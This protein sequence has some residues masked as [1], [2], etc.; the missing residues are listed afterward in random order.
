MVLAGNSVHDLFLCIGLDRKW[1]CFII[2]LLP[3][4]PVQFRIRKD[5]YG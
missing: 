4:F 5:L 2:T 1:Q 3:R